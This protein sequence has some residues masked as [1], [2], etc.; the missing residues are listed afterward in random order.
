MTHNRIYFIVIM[1]LIVHFMVPAFGF[2]DAGIKDRMKS[3]LPMILQLKAK[4]I[5][6][7][8][9]LGYLEFVGKA[10]E[11]AALVAAENADRKKVYTAIAEKNKTSVQNVGTRRALQIAKKTTPGHWIKGADGKWR[12][13]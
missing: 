4:G 6:G 7:E 8:N 2:A 5:V 1:S 3:R 11:K 9:H 10:K 12:K 13:K